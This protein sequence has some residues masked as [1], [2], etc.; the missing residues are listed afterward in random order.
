[1]RPPAGAPGGGG[2]RPDAKVTPEQPNPSRAAATAL[3]R[4]APG[5]RLRSGSLPTALAE[6]SRVKNEHAEET[7]SQGPAV[8]CD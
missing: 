8:A 2:C 1:M 3:S 6:L 7:G 5:Q 4:A